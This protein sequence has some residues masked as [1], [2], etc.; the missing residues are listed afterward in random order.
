MVAS[1]YPVSYHTAI[2]VKCSRLPS[3]SL[4]MPLIARAQALCAF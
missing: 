3:Q 2:I 4:E 1:E